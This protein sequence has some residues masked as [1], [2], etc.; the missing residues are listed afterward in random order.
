[1]ENSSH[2]NFYSFSIT[3]R[4]GHF[5]MTSLP[6]PYGIGDGTGHEMDRSM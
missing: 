6:T 3:T 1:M 4:L 2:P 5:C